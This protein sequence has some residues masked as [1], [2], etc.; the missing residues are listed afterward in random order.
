MSNVY[1][2]CVVWGYWSKKQV[3]CTDEF[4]R[5]RASSSWYASRQD[6]VLYLGSPRERVMFDI[7]RSIIITRTHTDRQ[8]D[9]QTHTHTHKYNNTYIYT[10]ISIY[11]YVHT[12]THQEKTREGVV[13][14]F[15][16]RTRK[17]DIWRPHQFWKNETRERGGW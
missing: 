9:R 8:T 14:S 10:Y 15:G 11:V 2:T 4:V 17:I 1:L 3:D 13:L 5:V 12:R 16:V 7:Y 6:V